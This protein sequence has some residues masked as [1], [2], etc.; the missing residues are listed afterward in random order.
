MLFHIH[1]HTQICDLGYIMKILYVCDVYDVCIYL[2][3]LNS[4][5]WSETMKGKV[6]QFY[7]I[8]F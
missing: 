4:M 2:I 3:L 1:K 5:K 8:T 6:D 7:G